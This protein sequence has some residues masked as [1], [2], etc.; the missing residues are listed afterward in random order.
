MGADLRRHMLTHEKVRNRFDEHKKAR[1]PKDDANQAPRPEPA[2]AAQADKAA[3]AGQADQAD[4]ADKKK[5]RRSQARKAGAPNVTV[6]GKGGDGHF[7][8]G[9]EPFDAR[10][11]CDKFKELYGD[12][13]KEAFKAK[14]YGDRV[15]HFKDGQQERELAVLKPI[16]RNG[17]NG[18]GDKPAYARADNTDGKMQVFTHVEKN[19]NVHTVTLND[20]RNLDRERGESINGEPM[21]NA[22]LERLAAIYNIST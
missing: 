12:D 14:E 1:R 2:K 22:F 7:K 21:E 17:L 15:G 13:Y 11:D 19:A 10:Q 6:A 8:V 3:Q 18:D 16:L 9:A 20:L 5:P 4:K